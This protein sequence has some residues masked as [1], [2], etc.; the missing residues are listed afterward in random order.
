MVSDPKGGTAKPSTPYRSRRNSSGSCETTS[1]STALPLAGRLLRAEE[2]FPLRLRVHLA[3]GTPAGAHTRR[4]GIGPDRTTC[5]HAG[6]SLR[7]NPGV[8]PTQ[9][10]DWGGHS[11]AVF[12][13]IYAKVI[14][15]QTACGRGS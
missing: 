12:L 10:A 8:P 14:A 11:V 4:E 13:K 2:C 3:Q 1:T 15:G 7:L 9:T 5:G 6:V